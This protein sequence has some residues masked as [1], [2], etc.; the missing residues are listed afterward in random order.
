MVSSRRPRI[1]AGSLAPLAAN[2][3]AAGLR[4]GRYQR[5]TSVSAGAVQ[6]GTA[7]GPWLTASRRKFVEAQINWAP[8]SRAIVLAPASRDHICRPGEGGPTGRRINPPAEQVGRSPSTS[9]PWRPPAGLRRGSRRRRTG[10]RG[11]NSRIRGPRVWW[12]RSS[13][14]PGAARLLVDLLASGC[15]C[16]WWP[17]AFQQHGR[18]FAS[19]VQ[20]QPSFR[21]ERPTMLLKKPWATTSTSWPSAA[22]S[23]SSRAASSARA[24]A[25]MRLSWLS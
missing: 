13:S 5:I 21:S 8:I 17:A 12:W 22:R 1:T 18:P 9:R 7:A 20:R 6:R 14:A 25:S 24:W 2:T 4:R 10:R 23:T 11:R 16:W 15:T 19:E 3:Y